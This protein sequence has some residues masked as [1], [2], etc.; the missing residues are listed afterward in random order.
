MSFFS[1]IIPTYKDTHRLIKCI[2]ALEN[3]TLDKALFE[4]IV[5]NNDPNEILDFGT[6]IQNDLK[7]KFLAENRPGSYAARNRGIKEAK[8]ELLAFT[9]SDCVPD[10]NWLK[11][12]REI[13][14]N[15]SSHELGVLTGPV[16]LFFRDPARLSPAEIYE[17]YTAFPI[18]SYAKEGFAVTANWFSYKSVVQEFGSFDDRLKSNG[19]SDLSGKISSKYKI[20]YSPSVIVNHPARQK[21]NELIQKYKRRIGGTY[22]RLYKGKELAFAVYILKFVFRRYRF[23][24]KKFFTVNLRDSFVIFFACNVINFAVLREFLLLIN[25]KDAKR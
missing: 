20:E 14:V 7:V 18:E 5:V 16:R 1:V 8:G 25:G 15:H 19:D 13:F 23:S 2:K 3:Q 4:V 10:K 12:A 9:D 11:N 24:L 6:E 21:T 17:K 22:T